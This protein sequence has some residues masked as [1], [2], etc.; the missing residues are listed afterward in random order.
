MNKHYFIVVNNIPR[1]CSWNGEKKSLKF[2]TT[3]YNLAFF[4]QNAL[5]VRLIWWIDIGYSLLFRFVCSTAG[6]IFY[7]IY[8]IDYEFIFLW[9]FQGKIFWKM[10]WKLVVL[11]NESVFN[12]YVVYFEPQPVHETRRILVNYNPH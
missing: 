12:A 8:Y 2:F 9:G 10:R 3:T 4:K 1:K 7:C 5:F 11:Q 6:T